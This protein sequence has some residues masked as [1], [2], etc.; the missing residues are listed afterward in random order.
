MP[1]LPQQRPIK[2]L[3]KGP[4]RKRFVFKSFSQRVEEVDLDVFR[5]LAPLKL[6][7]SGGTSFFHESLVSW[8]ELNSAVEFTFVYEQLLPIIQTL[9][10]L[11]LH[12][13]LVMN[14]LISHLQLSAIHSL[15][16]ILS[17]IAILSR[18]LRSEFLSFI[19]QFLGACANLFQSGGDREPEI[20]E[21]VFTS[22]SYIFKYLQKSLCKDI[23]F[24]LKATRQLRYYKRLY[25]Q[26][27]AAEAVSYL[28]RNTSNEQL[29][30]G[31][32]RVLVEVHL[33]PSKENINSCSSLFWY[34]LKGPGMTL[35][36]RSDSVLRLLLDKSTF[37]SMR[38]KDPGG[39]VIVEVLS[40]VLRRLCEE[41]DRNKL[42]PVWSCVLD[43]L[44]SV[45]DEWT[46]LS[47]NS[48]DPPRNIDPLAT[49]D[50]NSSDNCCGKDLEEIDSPRRRDFFQQEKDAE[51]SVMAN[52]L[53][54]LNHLVEFR[55]GSQ[56]HDFQPLFSLSYRLLQ[57]SLFTCGEQTIPSQNLSRSLTTEEAKVNQFSHQVWK[58][59]LNL[60]KSH[61]EGTGA[62]SGPSAIAS[63]APFWNQ[64]W[65]FL[66]FSSLLY[67]VRE[68]LKH[69]GSILQLFMDDILRMF[70][71]LI[72]TQS[73]HILPLTVKLFEKMEGAVHRQK[74]HCERLFSFVVST[75]KDATVE[76]L[77]C[78]RALHPRSI[79][80]ALKCYPYLVESREHEKFLVWNCILAL[81]QRLSTAQDESSDENQK[82][83]EFL[84]ATALSTE[85]KVLS[86]TSVMDLS[87]RAG[88][89]LKLAVCYKNSAIVLKCVADFLDLCFSELDGTRKEFV[90]TE[91]QEGGAL[92]LLEKNLGSPNKLLRLSTL[93]LLIHLDDCMV[94]SKRRKNL[95]GSFSKSGSVTSDNIFE[96]LQS[97]EAAP[98][99]L[100]A[101]RQSSLVFT[102][103]K[104]RA[105]TGNLPEHYLTSL[106][107]AMVGV[108]FN[109]FGLL[110]DAAVDS[111]S[112]LL[113][114]RK[115]A[116]WE[117]FTQHLDSCQSQFLYR[118]EVVL[119]K[120][121]VDDHTER[122][123]VSL[124]ESYLHK[125]GE[126]TDVGT[127]ATLLLKAAQKVPSVAE[128][129][130][131]QLIPLFLTFI[132]HDSETQRSSIQT[133]YSY[134]GK[135]W[136]LV[137]KEWLVLL[138]SMKNAQ[139][140]FKSSIL[141]EVL[142]NRFLMDADPDIQL[143]VLE[144]VLNW[145][146]SYLT[147]Y[148][149]HLKNLITPKMARE[150]MTTWNI[151]KESE[152]VQPNH[153]DNLVGILS[154]VLFPKI[155]KTKTSLHN[156]TTSGIQRKVVLAFL[157][158]LD[159][160]EL[161]LFFVLILKPLESAF[162]ED[163]MVCNQEDHAWEL[164][165]K[166][167]LQHNFIGWVD[168]EGTAKLS[169][170]KK[171]GFLHML[172][173][174]LET[175]DKDHIVP[176][177]HACLSFTFRI[178]RTCQGEIGG[179]A[180]APTSTSAKPVALSGKKDIR[181]LCLK[182]LA[183]VFSKYD[184]FEFTPIYWDSFF[185]TVRPMI[186]RFAEEGA[187]GEGPSALFSCF[188]AMSRSLALVSFLQKEDKIV[189]NLLPLLSHKYASPSVVGAA[190]TFVEN[191][192][193]LEEGEV[194]LT[195]RY[196]LPHLPLLLSNLRALLSLQQKG[197][198]GRKF[199]TSVKRGLQVLLKIGRHICNATDADQLLDVLLPF[200][201]RQKK[202]SQEEI[203][204]VL[205]ILKEL[206]HSLSGES[207]Q[208]T[209]PFLGQRLS[210]SPDL[211]VR[212]A[213]CQALSAFSLAKPGLSF[214]AG[215]IAD[216]NSL[217]PSTVGEYDYECR[218]GAYGRLTADSF[219]NLTYEQALI[220]ISQGLYDVKSDDI[221]IRHSASN[222]LTNFIHF[223]ASR[224]QSSKIGEG[225]YANEDAVATDMEECSLSACWDLEAVRVAVQKFLLPNIRKTM[226][227]DSLTVRR[228][229][230]SLLREMVSNLPCVSPLGELLPLISTDAEVDFFNNITHI[231]T[232]RRIRAMSRF[233][234]LCC[235]GNFSQ[236]ILVR[237]FEPLF[238]HSLFEAKGD[239]DGNLVQ[240]AVEVIA[241]I[242]SQLQWDP[243][244]SLLMRL[245]RTISS[246][247]EN[248]KTIIKL[249][250]S[251][252]DKFH[253][254]KASITNG[255]SIEHTCLE[256]AGSKS[257]MISSD[258]TEIPEEILQ[259]LKLHI[260][261]EFA[262][263]MVSKENIINVSVSLAV[264]KVLQLMPSDVMELELPRI[265]QNI[266]NLL[267]NRNHIVRDEARGGLIA[268]VGI[269]GAGYFGFVVEKLSDSL[270]RGY[271]VH[272][273]GFT[274]NALISR[275][276]PKLKVG[277]I[278]YCAEKILN[279]LVNDIF[280]DVADEKEVEKMAFK[281][282][283]IR[284]SGSYESL[285]LVAQIVTFHVHGSTLLQ[286]VRKK[287]KDAVIPKTKGKIERVLRQLAV[288]IQLNSSL[289]QEELFIFIYGVLEDGIADENLVVKAVFPDV[290]SQGGL[291]I[292]ENIPN[293]H[294]IR[295]FA[296]Q[297]FESH[298]KR[299]KLNKEDSSIL[300]LLDP[301]VVL[302][303]SCFE[304]RHGTI[305]GLALKC[306]CHLVRLPLPSVELSGAALLAK[307]LIMAQGFGKFEN[308]VAQPCFNLLV[309]I[310]K[311][312][313][314]AHVSEDHLRTILQFPVFIDLEKAETNTGLVILKAIV[315][316]KLLVPELYD[317]VNRVAQLMV[318]SH[319]A[320]VR[321][322]SSQIMLQFLLD[323]PLGSRRL[324]Q[325]LDFLIANLSY[326]NATGREA[327][328][329]M[330]H[331]IIVKFPAQTIDE[332]LETFFLPL[333]TRL[334]NDESNQLRAM[335][336]T[337]LKVLMG[338][339]SQRSLQRMLQ[340]CFSWLR[341]DK[342]QLWRA[343]GQVLGLAVEVMEVKFHVH[344]EDSL[345]LSLR[346]L[347]HVLE[348][349][350]VDKRAFSTTVGAILWQEAYYILVMLE[351]LI[352]QFPDLS[353]QR[354]S[355]GLW[356][357][358]ICFLVHQHVWVRKT[359]SRLLYMYFA[360]CCVADKNTEAV[361]ISKNG[362]QA[363]L[364]Q[365]SRLMQ[366]AA[367]LCQQAGSELDED[368]AGLLE[369]NLL[370]T[371]VALHSTFFDGK[372]RLSWLDVVSGKDASI[373]TRVAEAL[374]ILKVQHWMSKEGQSSN[375]YTSRNKETGVN[376]TMDVKYYGLYPVFKY[377]QRVSLQGD[378]LQMKTVFHL[379]D[380]F[381]T[382]LG[383]DG[384]QPYLSSMLLPL[385]RTAESVA[386]KIVA[387]D[388]K[389]V[390]E[391]VLDRIRETVGTEE[392]V[393]AYNETRQMTKNIRE[394]RK[395]A[396]KL[397]VLVDPEGHARK[398]LKLN[399]KR[400][401]QKKKKRKISMEG[402]GS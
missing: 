251:V 170:K 17:L 194:G 237:I 379:Y 351:K 97:V 307:L 130:T 304:S 89:F 240:A 329:E 131:R 24:I 128:G 27:F 345:D 30:K 3:N 274:L 397:Q 204:D 112:G 44:S 133:K 276:F 71:G 290:K 1:G 160:R 79:W 358:I 271:E 321:Q 88:D 372:G 303:Q 20:I 104:V 107:H 197:I 208:K 399:A 124:M 84:L 57:P 188:L 155:L 343:S 260:L 152:G 7:P 173:D 320:V 236:G 298:L 383:K 230:V 394:T 270:K 341:E 50:I 42:M 21:Q 169:H 312:A 176:Y 265:V 66:D 366:L 172:K 239:K 195:T 100:D 335:V 147:P 144:C 277:E 95:D 180:N 126:S 292:K 272:V 186:V 317:I 347:N 222:C 183:I 178:L 148:E 76:L 302:L 289:K 8:R 336:G 352:K 15:Q 114:T 149:D 94:A 332:Q 275:I 338:R 244:Y 266:V 59:V 281:M 381:L 158:S 145:K 210:S 249:L 219:G 72:D 46:V 39:Q 206:A 16:P 295:E 398:K 306:L 49:M 35:H 330:L 38:Q 375:G 228:E 110:W 259:Q 85:L 166:Q 99:S 256:E 355:E 223:L 47:S 342:Q 263:L 74:S 13:E 18:D 93:R 380:S 337:V 400:Q 22:V 73:M 286:T 159:V 334:V 106:T 157:A 196:L 60:I 80:A 190:L 25:I 257:L 220:V 12:K 121:E 269:L 163:G 87:S 102:R 250:C 268:V 11:I 164:A 201:H 305:L 226:T 119:T 81:D 371:S 82:L 258:G 386:A 301:M 238:T 70:D 37:R 364:L 96:Q 109:R 86:Q 217:S 122:S 396:N 177:L 252:L 91:L 221:S 231:Q 168:I 340:F 368:M 58:F 77:D 90:P 328:L 142:V 156:K 191:I 216:L 229:V 308:Q 153:R 311:H 5:S 78:T 350:G 83:W 326:V 101:G 382:Q 23:K 262:R 346:V 282:K 391:S 369:K 242:A 235:A 41:L 214:V 285:K 67:F 246:H 348:V 19:P 193:A 339:V 253:F 62:S 388:V 245:F 283:E 123:L 43:E 202:T 4:G 360:A 118:K 181:T 267:K 323:Y 232:H 182:V 300:S 199:S 40:H 273:R 69:G 143:K 52:L 103:L 48:N 225:T 211:D 395:R 213:V 325:H 297:L 14:T 284:R 189:P 344:L 139:S 354:S 113:E 218:I 141:K 129:R 367:I 205:R 203:V 294:L 314:S 175:F 105:C 233:K 138:S 29:I 392:F 33:K 161:S 390:A 212:L 162:T 353:L 324:Q 241:C 279:L 115:M 68:L 215:L 34:T 376:D 26:E 31:I 363:F 61:A 32:R 255:G 387:A 299:A 137:L 261:P 356:E 333:V 365:P 402:R 318:T 171:I 362:K 127:I 224:Y 310:L 56:V 247:P 174:I 120:E 54:L 135:D 291:T 184:N 248:E 254:T 378:D 359:S 370:F 287:L 209:L 28:L 198:S 140:Y 9:P 36:S 75:I 2:G 385:Y 64:L 264:V 315:G 134:G 179:G 243:Y 296:L 322:H 151:G 331:A 167:G 401:I 374:N 373:Q 377:L 51:K 389:T 185:G 111:L 65:K 393:Q 293:Y 108:L 98:F 146:D 349:N 116:V 278:D 200:L 361:Y 309:A 136:K 234:E 313:K 207:F 165:V 227:S 55:K 132:G 53:A 187:S 192:L 327:V 357:I 45:L 10:Q 125:D 92:S 154:R 63:H 316:R 288:G 384:V 319:V 150:E 6:E 117:I 280:E